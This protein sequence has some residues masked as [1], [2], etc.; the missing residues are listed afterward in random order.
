MRQGRKNNVISIWFECEYNL[1]TFITSPGAERVDLLRMQSSNWWLVWWI[2]WLSAWVGGA[3][4][5]AYFW[6]WPMPL[7]R[8]RY[9]DFYISSSHWDWRGRNLIFL[10]AISWGGLSALGLVFILAIPNFITFGAPQRR[11]LGPTLLWCI[12][13]IYNCRTVKFSLTLMVL[14]WF[15]LVWI[16]TRLIDLLYDLHKEE[17]TSIDFGVF[18]KL[19]LK[20]I[21][22]I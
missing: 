1:A 15:S 4:V 7:I 18:Y 17:I 22:R 11:I 14:H 12:F 2:M 13:P 16:G 8:F 19:E 5:L 6:I 21:F 20:L 3:G 9:P 10:K